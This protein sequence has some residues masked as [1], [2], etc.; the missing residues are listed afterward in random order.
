MFHCIIRISK[1]REKVSFSRQPLGRLANEFFLVISTAQIYL[2]S[3]FEPYT[4]A[5]ALE[6][7]DTTRVQFLAHK[8]TGFERVT[9]FFHLTAALASSWCEKLICHLTNRHKV[10]L[11]WAVVVRQMSWTGL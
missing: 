6:Q 3:F 10:M 5:R 2:D 1:S 8:C 4:S 11:S 9:A 7:R